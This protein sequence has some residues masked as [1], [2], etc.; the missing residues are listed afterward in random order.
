MLEVRIS[1]PEVYDESSGYLK[2]LLDL[3]WLQVISKP[4]P[5]PFQV[6][7]SYQ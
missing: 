3:L 1:F 2:R 7:A 4:L 5:K 6:V